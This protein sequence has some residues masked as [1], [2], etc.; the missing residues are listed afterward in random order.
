[1]IHLPADARL[2]VAVLLDHWRLLCVEVGCSLVERDDSYIVKWI[3]SG[4]T[5]L[6]GSIKVESKYLL[7][8]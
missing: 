7:P 8:K 3:Q 6:S 1:M 5:F 2:T 4:V